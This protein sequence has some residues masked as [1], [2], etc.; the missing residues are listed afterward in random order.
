MTVLFVATRSPWPSVDGGRVLMAHT[1]AGLRARGHAVTV[2]A[3]NP[4]GSATPPPDA[5]DLRVRLVP[6]RR[7]SW[8]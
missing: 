2:V 3:P 8:A 7:R 4:D 5:A 6:V 1:I